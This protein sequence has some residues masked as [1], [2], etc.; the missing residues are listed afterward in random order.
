M[1]ANGDAPFSS[2]SPPVSSGPPPFA[3]GP[4]GGD[5]DKI[6]FGVLALIFIGFSILF[7][8][9]GVFFDGGAKTLES[10]RFPTGRLFGPITTAKKN[11]VVE[12]TTRDNTLRNGWAFVEVEVLKDKKDRLLSFGGEYFNERGRDAEGP[13]TESKRMRNVKITLPEIGDYY[14]KF[15]V[16]GGPTLSPGTNQ[17]QNSVLYV[18]V[19]YKRGSSTALNI[20]GVILLIIGIALNEIRNKTIITFINKIDY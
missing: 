4:T 3:S 13:W 11:T 14:L 18:K 10:S 7:I 15:K 1:M 2:G 5:G 19:E 9:T 6:H 12:I 8:G 16:Q 17:T 20:I